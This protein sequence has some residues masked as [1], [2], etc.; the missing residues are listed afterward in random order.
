MHIVR[1]APSKDDRARTPAD[2]IT[3]GQT[4]AV[5]TSGPVMVAK[6]LFTTKTDKFTSASC[7]EASPQAR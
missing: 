2:H 6:L 5:T 4:E 1:Q 7:R 3:C